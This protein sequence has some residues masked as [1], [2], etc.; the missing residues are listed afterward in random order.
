M[1]TALISLLVCAHHC[2]FMLR[3]C[4][5]KAFYPPSSTMSR[6]NADGFVRY[7]HS[8]CDQQCSSPCDGV[9]LLDA[10]AQSVFEPW[11]HN[12][13]VCCATQSWYDEHD[14]RTRLLPASDSSLTFARNGA[15]ASA[16]DVCA[17]NSGG[18]RLQPTHEPMVP[19][20]ETHT[21]A[22]LK[23]THVHAQSGGVVHLI[24]ADQAQHGADNGCDD[25]D[26]DDAWQALSIDENTESA[27]YV[28]FRH[29][30]MH[31]RRDSGDSGRCAVFAGELPGSREH[32]STDVWMHCR[33]TNMR[34][35]SI[36]ALL[37]RKDLDACVFS[38]VVE[39]TPS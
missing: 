15:V 4:V 6:N 36:D 22:K 8:C 23:H 30:P 11:S 28:C 25:D 20:L 17:I 7:A 37:P 14:T 1:S 39:T 5:A 12:D 10:A 24:V 34:H 35:V 21:Q 27:L 33:W 31:G 29:A 16:A 2:A 26:E 18:L 38:C 3:L 19:V 32:P 9:V 13:T